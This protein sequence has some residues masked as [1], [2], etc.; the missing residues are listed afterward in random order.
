VIYAKAPTIDIPAAVVGSPHV[1]I[2][3][4]RHGRLDVA[5]RAKPRLELTTSQD[6]GKRRDFVLGLEDPV[7][8]LREEILGQQVDQR[9]IEEKPRG[10]MIIP[11]PVSLFFS[12]LE[13]DTK[14]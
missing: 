2:Q 14:I 9:S 8:F 12:F 6:E 1:S 5:R 3:T 4:K 7:G 13:M 10:T 11:Q